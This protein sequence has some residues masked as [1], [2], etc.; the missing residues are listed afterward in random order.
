MTQHFKIIS[1]SQVDDVCSLINLKKPMAG[2]LYQETMHQICPDICQATFSFD[3]DEIF[4]L[5]PLSVRIN[6]ILNIPDMIDFYN[7]DTGEV[8]FV[9]NVLN[10][11]MEE[12]K[13]NNIIFI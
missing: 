13:E 12:V 10:G 5:I 11:T 8:I 1:K 7:K 3:F 2:E 4:Y 9:Y 6:R